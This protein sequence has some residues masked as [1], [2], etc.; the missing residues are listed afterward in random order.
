MPFLEVTIEDDCDHDNELLRI[1]EGDVL[2]D[3]MLRIC[4]FALIIRHLQNGLP[5]N[6]GCM[7]ELLHFVMTQSILIIGDSQ[8]RV[9]RCISCVL[10]LAHP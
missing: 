3:W 10:I 9:Q 2:F 5:K 1:N 4:R 8:K 6:D 7:I